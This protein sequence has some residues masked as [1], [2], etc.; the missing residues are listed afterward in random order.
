M[1]R[2]RYYWI[3]MVSMA[4]I[5]CLASC[6][7][8]SS[9]GDGQETLPNTVVPL[10]LTFAV[11]SDGTNNARTRADV[12]DPGDDTNDKNDWDRLTVIIAYKSKTH[13]ANI[14][15][16]EPNRMVYYD[17]FTKEQFDK[18]LSQDVAAKGGTLSKADALGY[19][20]YTRYVP[21][22]TCRVYGVV[23]S[24][25]QGFDLEKLLDEIAEDGADKTSAVEALQ[26]SND[27]AT[28]DGTMDIAKFISLGTGYALKLD[29]TTNSLT[30]NQDIIVAF[31]DETGDTSVEDKEYWRMNIRR[32][33][34]KLDIQWDTK[35]VYE[36]G[37]YKNIKVSSFTYAGGAST[38]SGDGSSTTAAGS[39]S[40]RLFPTLQSS[41]VAAVGGKK[42]FINTSEISQRN[43]RQYHYIFPD[44][45]QSAKVTF[46]IESELAADEANGATTKN[47]TFDFKNQVPLKPATWYKV[48]VTISGNTF[49]TESS[50]DITVD[51]F[52]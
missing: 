32:L 2:L 3:M 28:K 5:L 21:L 6:S 51:D 41:G 33:A 9:T 20:Q 50:S 26:I 44:G 47:Y 19:R 17:T 14:V 35:K 45:S 8:G 37:T 7:S 24:H 13:S 31:K 16:D 25:D 12:P 36:N 34:T 46:T 38:T 18:S 49:G 22:G 23:Y 30:T 1:K 11:P 15:D 10:S 52:N 43:G 27:Y 48:N 42:T 4:L 40:G 39:G 29:N